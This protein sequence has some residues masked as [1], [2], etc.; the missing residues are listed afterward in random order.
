MEDVEH[1]GPAADADLMAA[2]LDA[3]A[4]VRTTTAPNP[5]VGAAICGA[6]GT[7]VAGATQPPGGAHAEIMAIAAARNAGVEL[8]GATLA[9]TLE[10]CSHT[11]R[12]GP[13]TEALIDAGIARVVVA[14]EDPDPQV[15]GS[16][17]A[18]LRNAGLDVVVGCRAD[19][20]TRQLEPYLHHRQTGRPYVIVKLAATLDGRTAA[21]DGTSQWI[22]GE[23]ARTD[24]HRL[25]AESQA[26]VV[27]A[28][29]VRADDPSLT[30]RLVDGPSPQ[31]VVLGSA[32]PDAKIHPCLE[33]RG[34]LAELLDHLGD[35][36]VLQVMVEGGANT[37]AQFSADGLVNRY[38][39]Y[40]A[41]AMFGG[42]DARPLF[43]GSGAATIDT[44]PRG[45]FENVMQLGEDIRLELVID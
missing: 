3:A 41:P 30:T 9:T 45:R 20:A 26:I 4:L 43:V 24:G 13:C 19:E 44:L 16:G 2:A 25:R 34:D 33:W 22:T 23:A 31:R 40:L 15:S 14:I 10:P 5:W 35:A 27:G 42:D 18:A 38:V 32:P 12:T 17:V 21:P 36:G 6:D 7:V 37:I 39:T 1:P 28:G 8:A 29:T 11:G